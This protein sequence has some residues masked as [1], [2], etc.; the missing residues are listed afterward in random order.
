MMGEKHEWI[1]RVLLMACLL[2]VSGLV[3]STQADEG[4]IPTLGLVPTDMLDLGVFERPSKGNPK[5]GSSL[6]Q[7]LEVHQQKGTAE[8]QT[9]VLNHQMVV[10]DDRVQVTIITADNA[11]DQVRNAVEVAGGKYELHYQNRLQAMV[12]VGVLE[13]LTNR[14]D[15]LVIREPRRA[16]PDNE[17]P[18]V[19]MA[20]VE[21]TEGVSASNAG[22]W[23]TAG[24]SGNGTRVA[25]IDGGFTGY[26]GL[27]GTDLPSAVTTYD[28]SGTGMG[29]VE[30]GTA[31]AEVVFDIAPG[32]TMDLHKV[33]TPEEIGNAVTQAI[34]DGVKIISMSMGWSLDGPGDGTG[35]LAGIVKEARSNGIFFA[36]AAG[37]NAEACWSGTFSDTN[38]DDVHEWVPGGLNVNY[39]GP[40]DGRVLNL[41]VGAPVFVRL[42]WNDWTVVDQDYDLYLLYYDGSA[43]QLV[44]NSTDVQDGG[45]GQTPEEE[46]K[47]TAP[48]EGAYGVAVVKYNATRD[49]CLRIL[50][51]P[52]YG[53]DKRV[54]ERSLSFPADSPDAIT[55]GAVDVSSYDLEPYSSQGPTFGP[56]GHCDGGAVKPDL[57]A[58]ANVSTMSYGAQHF[59]G[60]SAA[61]PHVA[62]AV[63]LLK[64][65]YPSYTVDDLQDYL[66]AEAIDQGDTGKDNLYGSGRLYLSNPPVKYTVTFQADP[67]GSITGSLEQ[68]VPDGGDC[69]AV[70]AVPDQGYEFKG[71]SGDY[72]GTDNPLT[73]HGVTSDM[74]ITANFAS[75]SDGGDSG[76]GDGEKS[77][78]GGGGGCFISSIMPCN[79]EGGL[80]YYFITY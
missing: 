14:S 6:N 73:I 69:E 25:I 16:V 47:I 34:T 59:N 52:G 29:E 12:P 50:T 60:T 67:G 26:S 76:E 53:L 56:G 5:L 68:V 49:V 10:R 31:C 77:G 17:M 42:H 19:P 45:E 51:W 9:F 80:S 62:G 58:Y 48:F 32:I 35:P 30:H 78:G 57:A 74:N 71:W 46:I 15:V 20:G 72:T 3:F 37:N 63:A 61:T 18:L 70:T 27:L 43:W 38:G 8:V 55:V 4:D 11:I 66:E 13:V 41:Q 64:E 28:W 24:Y 36:V 33:S 65:A 1:T 39:F 2:F 44:A 7:L 23:H 21:T 75:V 22:A 79:S 54:P 40:G